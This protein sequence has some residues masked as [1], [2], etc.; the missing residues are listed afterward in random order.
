MTEKEKAKMELD[1]LISKKECLKA[2][3]KSVGHIVW[4]FD[5]EKE[6]LLLQRIS[7]ILEDEDNSK[8][9]MVCIY[10]LLW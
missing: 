9:T 6:L 8:R 3:S 1:V 5:N 2:I 10:I 4:S 7:K